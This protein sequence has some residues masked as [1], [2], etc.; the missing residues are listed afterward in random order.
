ME[1]TL[2]DEPL[3]RALGILERLV[4]PDLL[5]A[6]QIAQRKEEIEAFLQ[7]A[8]VAGHE[9]LMAKQLESTY[10]VGKRGKKW[11][12]IKPADH[13]D[14]VITAAEWGSGRTRRLAVELLAR[15]ARRQ[16]GAFQMIGKTF[17]GLTDEE[18][19]RR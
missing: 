12:K 6:R 4:P 19:S 17:K 15:G 18:C 7:E 1:R 11:F 9:G 16:G 10:S 13:L 14:L 8:L 2:I 5:T 3:P